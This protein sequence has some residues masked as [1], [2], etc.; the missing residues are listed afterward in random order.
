MFRATTPKQV[1]IFNINPALFSKIL[2]TYAQGD[3]II[4]E[5]TQDDLQF[6]ER[7]NESCNRTE[8]RAW[9]R[10]TQEEAN[11]FNARS[12][13][14]VYVQV[15]ALTDDDEALAS[16]IHQVYVNDVLDDEVL[17]NEI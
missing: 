12:T 4:L 13:K 14:K 16:K 17:T 8:Y 2:I 1:F 11:E 15:R 9:F 3:D 10:M 7:F 5:K 6:E